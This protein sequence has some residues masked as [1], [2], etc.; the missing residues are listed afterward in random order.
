MT[1]NFKNTAQRVL[2]ALTAVVCLLGCQ[3][4]RAAD[5][6]G[7]TSACWIYAMLTCIEHEAGM[8]G[9]SV[10]LSR[11]WL[12]SK[13]LEEQAASLYLMKEHGGTT[14]LYGA[15]GISSRG[16]GPEAIRLAE[17]Y[18]FVPYQNEK[19]EITKSSVTERKLWLLT[20][21]ARSLG[22]LR[23]RMEKI[24]PR[25]TISRN[26]ATES[27][28]Q[29]LDGTEGGHFYY[30]SMRYNPHQFAESLMYCQRWEFFAS[31]PYHPYGKPFV[32]EI[33]DNYNRHEY[34]NLPPDELTSRVMESLKAGHAVY[35]EYGH[36]TVD[37][38]H[39]SDH[40]VAIVGFTKSR[41]QPGKVLLKCKNSYG[42]KWGR[43]GYMYV[44]LEDFRNTTCNVG[45]ITPHPSPASGSRTPSAY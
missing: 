35:W 23:S 10:K 33:P 44:S 4:R 12:L 27:R 28:R 34:I 21:Q 14:A 42:S 17:R 18:G 3:D 26:P 37:G 9:D 11:Q 2:I 43:G 39:T 22:E 6:Q 19:T 38:G 24:L 15:R 30:L 7:K 5:D 36:K 41:K 32:L 31:V 25:F 29:S 20:Q 45:V 8:R 40:A 1:E 13:E 16:V